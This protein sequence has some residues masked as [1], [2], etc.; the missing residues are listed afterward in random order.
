MG[1]VYLFIQIG[2]CSQATFLFGLLL[3]YHFKVIMDVCY[4]YLKSKP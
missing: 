1:T 2:K 4:L 3:R